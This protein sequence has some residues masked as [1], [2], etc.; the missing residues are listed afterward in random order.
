LSVFSNFPM[1]VVEVIDLFYKVSIIIALFY[2]TKALRV[3]I[4][5]N[6][7]RQ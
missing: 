3:Y 6:S 4:N 5:K 2:A 1:F 7:K